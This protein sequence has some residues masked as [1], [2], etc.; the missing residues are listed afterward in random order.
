MGVVTLTPNPLCGI[1]L[2]RQMFAIKVKC[3]VIILIYLNFIDY[4]MIYRL[5]IEQT[6]IDYNIRVLFYCLF[7]VITS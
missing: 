5:D 2:I 4:F 1:G 3:F 6:K 7:L